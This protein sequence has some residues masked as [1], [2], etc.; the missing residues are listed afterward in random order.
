MA[1]KLE[2]LLLAMVGFSCAWCYIG[3]QRLKRFLLSPV[4]REQV[5]PH[6]RTVLRNEPFILDPRLPAS[7]FDTP[8][9]IYA[10][11]HTT[12][13]QKN[14]LPTKGLYY[15]SKVGGNLD[16]FDRRIAAAAQ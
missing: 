14:R 6:V 7:T 11:F 5:A 12:P 3:S 4:Y 16:A 2:L 8:E 13:Y 9:G 10:A 15:G 1:S